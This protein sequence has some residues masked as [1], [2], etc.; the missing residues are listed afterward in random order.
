REQR[1]LQQQLHVRQGARAP[2]SDDPGAQLPLRDALP[3]RADVVRSHRTER[4]EP[5][6]QFD[7]PMADVLRV[8]RLL[9]IVLLAACTRAAKGGP[10]G[11]STA[12]RGSAAGIAL[13][14]AGAR[15]DAGLPDYRSTFTKIGSQRFVSQGH[16]AERFEAEVWANDAAKG[17]LLTQHGDVPAG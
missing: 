16:A 5:R 6:T 13:A 2:S 14:D 4:R 11:V 3:R 1:R 12:A 8:G 9:L 15:L 17:P 10:V 7:A